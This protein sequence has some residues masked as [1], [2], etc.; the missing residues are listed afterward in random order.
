MSI[1]AIGLVAI[2]VAAWWF[3][4]GR[5]A[6][7]ATDWERLAALDLAVPAGNA[8]QADTPWVKFGIAP[9]R[10]GEANTIQVSLGSPR[11]TPVPFPPDNQGIAA[12]TAQP[13]SGEAAP[14]EALELTAGEADALVAS[15]PLDRPGWWHLSATVD[16]AAEPANLYLLL[17]DP[18]LNGPGAVQQTESSP[19]AEALFQRGLDAIHALR[20]LRYSQWLAD[21]RGN[22]G[23]SDHAVRAGGDGT[24]AALTY[25]AVGGMDAVIIDDTRWI[26][27]PGELGWEQQEG[28]IVVPPSEWGEEYAGATGFTI[29]G[30]ETVDGEPCQLL[31]FVVP[32]TSEPRR[33]SAAWYLW[34]VGNDTGHVRRE[35]MVSRVH[36]MLNHFTDFDAPLDIV[37]PDMASPVASGTPTA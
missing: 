19:E 17:P 15:S 22:V 8:F 27:L 24:P 11:G 12:L 37:P 3:L 25:R 20:T 28:A 5:G 6:T 18:N 23:I 2:A 36:Y 4:A 35:A 9:A 14:A 7:T 26:L 34:W 30:E 21:G 1:A 32:E 33:Q 10:P 29:L 13:L 16:G 31:A